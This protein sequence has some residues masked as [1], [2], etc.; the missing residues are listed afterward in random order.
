M[1][2][3]LCFN[4]HPFEMNISHPHI[5]HAPWIAQ[6]EKKKAQNDLKL[7]NFEHTDCIWKQSLNSLCA[8]LFVTVVKSWFT[9]STYTHRLWRAVGEVRKA[10]DNHRS[11]SP[12]WSLGSP[13]LSV[14]RHVV[15][16]C[17]RQQQREPIKADVTMSEKE[18]YKEWN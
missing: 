6:E 9:G 16:G 8:D 3:P 12:S 7:W 13:K 18:F 5:L 2:F 11:I 4:Q 10:V 14:L 17:A 15:Q 1:T